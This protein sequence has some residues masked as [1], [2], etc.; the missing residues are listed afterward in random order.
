MASDA[1]LLYNSGTS[2][3]N[4]DHLRLHPE[5]EH[6]RVPGTVHR[7]EEILVEDIIMG[8]MTVVAD[9]YADVAAPFP[10]GKL[11]RHHVAVHAGAGIIGKIRSG[12]SDIERQKSKPG[13]CSDCNDDRKTPSPRWD[14][15]FEKC[16]DKLLH[17]E[18]SMP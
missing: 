12:I 8:N 6:E 9:R 3:V 16:Y 5:R 10:G 2:V 1:I 15:R 11:R 17:A 18:N 4:M 14:E 7:F 13:Q